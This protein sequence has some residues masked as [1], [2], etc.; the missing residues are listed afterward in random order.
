[1]RS[2]RHLLICLSTILLCANYGCS[3]TPSAKELRVIGS[4]EIVYL[5]RPANLGILASS[6]LFM[7]YG[8]TCAMSVG[9]FIG[10]FGCSM[11][12]GGIDA[13]RYGD[14]VATQQILAVHAAELDS[15][16]FNDRAYAA[17]SSV[18]SGTSWLKDKGAQRIVWSDSEALFTIKSKADSVIYLQPTFMISPDGTEF[19]VY[20]LAGIQKFSPDHPR[21]VYDLRRREFT[22]VH[23]LTLVKPGMSWDQQKAAGHELRDM[24]AKHALL[25]WLD[26]DG[27]R[28]RT[29]FAGDLQQIDQGMREMFGD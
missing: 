29:A 3:S 28:L 17:F 21:D 7:K 6:S 27:A 24:D 18:I 12:L 23:K 22:F 2:M 15:L 20:A 5:Q 26:D 11:I 13:A 25:A 14:P 8:A 1:M 16:G 19:Y 10:G 9:G 4:P